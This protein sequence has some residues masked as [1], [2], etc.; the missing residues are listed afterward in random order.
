MVKNMAKKDEESEETEEK[1][2]IKTEVVYDLKDLPGVG[3]TTVKK[4]KEAGIVSIRTLAIYPIT[5]L[6]DEAG[7]GEKTAQKIIKAAQDIENMGF[8]SADIIWE[9]R[10]QLNRLTTSS[11]TLDEIL[12]GGIEP[13]SLT[14]FYGEYR[15]GKTQLAHQL[16]VNVQL[17]Y[18]EG[19][20]E[21]KAL[22]IDTEATFRPERII[23][24]AEAKDL[25]YNTVLKN[26][27]VG[28]AY[29]SDHQ[30]LLIQEASKLINEKNI[31][32]I[33]VD[34]IIGH[35]RSEY[36]GRGTLANR[37]QILNSHIHDLLRL[38]EIYDEL[39]VI[40]TNQVSSKPDV[41]YGNPTVATGGNIVA[42][43][44]T[45]RVYLR[46]GKGEQRVAKIIDAP[47]LAEAEA[48]FSITDDG[49]KD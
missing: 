47:H 26:I 12:A 24:M 31:K 30:V 48:I 40:F 37:Q 39:A 19:G 6:M 7:I 21:G 18:E 38:T 35:F 25:D 42:H 32:L 43:G 1:G 10:R 36:V 16:C 11:S 46:K 13:G 22:Y 4:L 15:T 29:N 8:K 9:K 23:Q 14:E 27:T 3:D 5:K 41:F 45:I 28:R 2:T 49:I 20:L 33:V 17:P 34:S 44:A